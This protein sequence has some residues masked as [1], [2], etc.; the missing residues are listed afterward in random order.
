VC[1]HVC[2]C[3]C[4]HVRVCVC[5]RDR[6]S[7]VCVSDVCDGVYE[8]ATCH[9]LPCACGAMLLQY[10]THCNTLKYTATHHNTL[11]Q[12]AAQSCCAS[13][14]L[15]AHTHTDT[16]TCTH[17]HT[18]FLSLTRANTQIYTHTHTQTHTHTHACTHTHSLSRWL[19]ASPPRCW[20]RRAQ[21][22]TL[23]HTHT[24]ALSL[25]LSLSHTHTRIHAHAHTRCQPVAPRCLLET[26][27]S[28]ALARRTRACRTHTR[29]HTN[30]HTQ[31]Q[32]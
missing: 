28:A 31:T 21:T 5:V 13:T 10:I 23:T 17:T 14:L 26:A 24:H 6:M 11:Y 18:L 22:H 1:V 25:S 8:R 12:P 15:E 9:T 32:T 16:H 27:C 29:T 3:V 20:R 2:V 19:P 30:T 7:W 4:V